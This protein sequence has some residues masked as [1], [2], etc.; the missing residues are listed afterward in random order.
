MVTCDFCTKEFNNIS[1][2]NHHKKTAKYCL[3]IQNKDNTEFYCSYCLNNFTTKDS[4]NNHNNICKNKD[5][6]IIKNLEKENIKLKDENINLEKENIK[7][8]DENI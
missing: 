2:L 1:S 7:L 3:K 6:F 5:N 4:L 8:K